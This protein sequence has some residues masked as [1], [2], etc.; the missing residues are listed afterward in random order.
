[1][2]THTYIYTHNLLSNIS[3]FMDDSFVVKLQDMTL[4]FPRTRL[5]LSWVQNSELPLICF[6]QAFHRVPPR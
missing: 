2:Y 6:Y 4:N 5:T 3:I 1:M